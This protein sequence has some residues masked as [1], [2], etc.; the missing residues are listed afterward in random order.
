MA[1]LYALFIALATFNL[2]TE[3]VKCD[4]SCT[5]ES[6]ECRVLLSILDCAYEEGLSPIEGSVRFSNLPDDIIGFVSFLYAVE[7]H[8]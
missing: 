8:T 1:L 7:N 5:Y 2:A 4:G 6:L 3:A